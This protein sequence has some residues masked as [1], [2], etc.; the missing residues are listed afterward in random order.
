[1]TRGA[2][3]CQSADMAATAAATRDGEPRIHMVGI[4]ALKI[5]AAP[6]KLRTVLGSCVGIVLFD[7][8]LR[9][10]GLAHS[11]LPQGSEEIEELGKFADQAVDNLVVRLTA[12]GASKTRLRAKLVGGAAMFETA[13][14]GAQLGQRNVEAA[15]RRFQAHEIPIIAEAVG[16]TKGR[17]VRVHPDT[18][19]VEVAII[20][21]E[22][23]II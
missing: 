13:N 17:K 9:I 18:G 15:R 7:L 5:A 23:V 19:N 4:G 10:A 3:V 14:N 2:Q 8:H 16:G 11:I 6:E 22:P 20:G 12:L 21:S 1:M